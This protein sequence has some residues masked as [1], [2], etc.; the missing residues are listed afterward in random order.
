MA[1]H[2]ISCSNSSM[3]QTIEPQMSVK[4]WKPETENFENLTIENQKIG[5]IS[6]S[7]IL[8]GIFD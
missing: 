7:E 1:D 6:N 3:A 5:K 4:F 2:S 8:D